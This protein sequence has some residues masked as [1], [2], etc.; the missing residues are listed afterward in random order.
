MR[1]TKVEADAQHADGAA[2]G[3]NESAADEGRPFLHVLA[4]FGRVGA[5]LESA[6]EIDDVLRA[7]VHEVRMLV[8]VARCSIHLRD[9]KAGLF[10][11]CVGEGGDDRSMEHIKRSLAG[12][13]ADGMTLELL[14]TK[15]PVIIT[16]ARTDARMIRSN[17]RF[18]N[19]HSMMAVPMIF[20]G[21]V[22]GIIYLDDVDEPYLFTTGDAEI[23]TVFAQLAA[24]AVTHAQSRIELRSKLD[25]SERQIHALRRAAAVEERLGDLVLEGRCLSD[26]V[27]TL[28]RVLGKP[29]AI[30]DPDHQRLAV[31]SPECADGMEPRLLEPPALAD[32]VVRAAVESGGIGR[33]FLVPPHPDAGVMHR[34]LVAPIVVNDELWGRLVVM[35]YRSRF[36]GG[37]MLTLRRAAMLVALYMRTERSAI[38]ADWNAGA[39]LAA[40]ILDG[41]SDPAIVERRAE[42]LGVSLDAPHAV[43]L[44]GSRDERDSAVSDFRAVAAAFRDLS[45][46]LTVHATKVEAGVAVILQVPEGTECEEFAE[47]AKRLLPDVCERL[48][49]ADRIAAGL[50]A[51]GTQAGSYA[52]LYVEAQQVLE[53]IRRFGSPRGPAALSSADLGTGRVFLATSDAE[54]VRAFADDTF[55]ELVAD[56]SKA[57]LLTTLCCFFANM[58]SIRRCAMELGVHENTIRYRLARIE[59]LTG[60]CVT[61]DPDAQL[62]ARLSLL[63]LMT[64][65]KLASSE[66]RK[67]DGTDGQPRG[68]ALNL[69]GALAG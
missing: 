52:D 46:G 23:A 16:N 56:S 31:A 22:I 59:E 65:G 35:E 64:Q 27:E 45:P 48:G 28:A 4:A 19:I 9:E 3:A 68:E 50:S 1:S 17:T 8:G 7:I 37:D 38:E 18:W 60:L 49:G 53:C 51:V 20:A 66:P 40:E 58:A 21:E 25:A 69:V 39:S 67:L 15:R 29:C 42:R 61:H 30:Y 54:A 32:D 57:D 10:R 26:I 41:C 13:P 33:P 44:I 55:G 47:F 5:A 6:R 43:A 36:V 12:M 2:E 14:R 62:G 63:V 34:H 24:V 11:G